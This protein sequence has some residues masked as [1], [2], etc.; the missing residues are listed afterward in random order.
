MQDILIKTGDKVTCPVSVI[1]KDGKILLGH[2]HYTADKWKEI[3][4]WT[5]PGGRCD[6]GETVEQ[7]LRREVYEETGIKDLNIEKY[8]G[9]V[10]GAKEGDNVLIFAAT[11]TEEP[12]LME[13]EKFSEWAWF[14][15][16][17]IPEKF[18]NDNARELI[19]KSI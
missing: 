19:I 9:E 17:E 3:S 15:S 11:T 4:V 5:V 1:I 14:N 12:I 8:L 18:I 6:E 2:R 13:P 16:N 7:T 10:P